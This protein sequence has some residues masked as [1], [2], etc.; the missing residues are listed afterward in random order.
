MNLINLFTTPELLASIATFCLVMIGFIIIIAGP[1]GLAPK[2]IKYFF[3]YASAVVLAGVIW[4]YFPLLEE[5]LKNA[6]TPLQVAMLLGGAFVLLIIFLSII[7]GSR[8]TAQVA[9]GLVVATIVETFKLF[10]KF[11]YRVFN[12]LLRPFTMR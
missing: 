1:F 4:A 5:M 12:L 9:S 6:R 11:F 7:F 3:R 8:F 10:I 2:V